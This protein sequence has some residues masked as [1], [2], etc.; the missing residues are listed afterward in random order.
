MSFSDAVFEKKLVG[1]LKTNKQTKK[2]KQKGWVKCWPKPEIL[3]LVFRHAPW[4]KN[5][6]KH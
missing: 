2:K 5:G 3:R 4:I 6:M 1:T